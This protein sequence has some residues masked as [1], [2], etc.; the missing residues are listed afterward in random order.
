MYNPFELVHNQ[1]GRVGEMLL[2][3]PKAPCIFEGLSEI[4][5]SEDTSEDSIPIRAVSVKYTEKKNLKDEI[6]HNHQ[7]TDEEVSYGDLHSA[8]VEAI[9][10]KP[11]KKRYIEF[12]KPD[13][14]DYIEDDT[15]QYIEKL[16]LNFA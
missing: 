15:E 2:K 10:P 11:P 1:K 9:A 5:Q 8:Q 12:E 13:D 16:E 7:D 6:V 14:D 3:R 4:G